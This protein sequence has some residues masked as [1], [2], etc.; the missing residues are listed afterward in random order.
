MAKRGINDFSKDKVEDLF[1]RWSASRAVAA[2]G[3][4]LKT[5]DNWITLVFSNAQGRITA[6]VEY[7]NLHKLTPQ[8]ISGFIKK[9]TEQWSG[10]TAHVIVGPGDWYSSFEE[11][12]APFS[13]L[14]NPEG[15]YRE[16]IA[17]VWIDGELFGSITADYTPTGQDDSEKT[18]AIQSQ[19]EA[20]APEGVDLREPDRPW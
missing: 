9:E 14:I 11:G 20:V 16:G 8:E 17:S 6:T 13:A 4:H 3:A 5:P 10:Y 7:E 1:A 18:K 12:A 2:L 15:K 19:V